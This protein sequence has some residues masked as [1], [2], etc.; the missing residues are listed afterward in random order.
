MPKIIDSLPSLYSPLFPTLLKQEIPEETKA[1]CANCAMCEASCENPVDA[2]DGTRRFFRPDTKCCTFHPKLPNYLVGAILRDD[3][4]EMS[5]GRKRIRAKIRERSGVTPLEIDAPAKYSLLYKQTRDFFGKAPS[6]RC[7]YFEET[8]GL[9]TIWRYREAVC[10]TFF[11]KYERGADGRKF[12]SDLKS[13]LSLSEIQLSRYVLLEL[14]PEFIREERHRSS[15]PGGTLSL[16]ELEGAAPPE[17]EYR[18]LWGPWLGREEEF[19]IQSFEQVQNL[20]REKFEQ[21]LG[22]DARIWEMQLEKSSDA[23]IRPRLPERLKFNPK[24]TVK[25][26]PDGSLALGAYSEHDAVALPGLAYSLLI[27]F[28]G[29]ESTDNVRRR[30]RDEKQADLSEEVLLTLYQ[31]RILTE[32]KA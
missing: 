30:L 23:V 24:A 5:E 9:C 20:E 19:Y 14:F 32:L 27:E 18:R 31:H 17:S 1:T 2:V 25:W 11:C 21:I 26:L 13:Y 3:S 10:S 28:N 12:W 8:H 6:M 7:P 15:T 16:E 29:T 22:L 4:P